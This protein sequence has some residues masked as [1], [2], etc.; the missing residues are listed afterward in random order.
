MHGMITQFE[1]NPNLYT[2]TP[3]LIKRRNQWKYWILAAVSLCC[4]WCTAWNRQFTAVI[5]T[6]LS[7]DEHFSQTQTSCLQ[8]FCYQSVYCIIRY[9]LVRINIAKCFTNNSKRFRCSRM[10]KR[11]AREYTMFAPAQL[12]RNRRE[13]RPSKQSDLDSSATR[14]VGRFYYTEVELLLISFLSRSNWLFG[15]F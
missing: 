14:K 11:S 10:N 8:K 6:A 5:L 12:L 1:G 3:S 2:R 9:F 13:Q 7:L 4:S 15:A